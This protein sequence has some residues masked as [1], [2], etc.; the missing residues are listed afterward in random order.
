VRGGEQHLPLESDF[1]L[2]LRRLGLASEPT[3]WNLGKMTRISSGSLQARL[4]SHPDCAISTL[5]MSHNH[6]ILNPKHCIIIIIIIIITVMMIMR[7][8]F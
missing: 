7:L 5:P 8:C 2:L 1:L 3:E 6:H 4:L